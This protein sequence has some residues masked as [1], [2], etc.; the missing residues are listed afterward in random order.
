MDKIEE[1][2]KLKTLLEKG[3]ITEKEFQRRKDSII[4]TN[5]DQGKDQNAVNKPKEKID[6]NV[7]QTIS[8]DSNKL[9]RAGKAIKASVTMI[10][11]NIIIN[12][13]GISLLMV[14]LFKVLV[15]VARGGSFDNS[16][17]VLPIFILIV[18]T[19]FFIIALS[20]MSGAGSLFKKLA[21]DLKREK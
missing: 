2:K 6:T 9:F 21:I 15:V 20:E 16:T 14:R 13:I 5:K 4:H 11:F 8:L 10:V 1:I 17:L 18:S 3:E 19:I 7:S 12:F